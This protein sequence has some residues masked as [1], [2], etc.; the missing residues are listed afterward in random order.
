MVYGVT[1]PSGSLMSDSVIAEAGARSFP[2][3]WA[4]LLTHIPVVRVELPGIAPPK[5]DRGCWQTRAASK[6]GQFVGHGW[7]A[8]MNLRIQEVV[9]SP[10]T[11]SLPGD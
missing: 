6:I 11:G 4:I 1:R 7:F 5:H 10:T 3:I 9:N 2:R 8:S